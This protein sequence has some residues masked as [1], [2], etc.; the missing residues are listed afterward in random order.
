MSYRLALIAEDISRVAGGVPAVISQ[1][2]R[3]VISAGSSVSLL[4]AKGATSEVE[5]GVEGYQISPNNSLLGKLWQWNSAWRRLDKTPLFANADVVHIH[6]CWSAPQYYASRIAGRNRVPFIFSA[7]GMLE[8]WLWKGLGPLQFLKK[9]IYWNLFAKNALKRARVVHAITTLEEKNLRN[10]FGKNI[11]IVVIP[12]ALD[13]R[14]YCCEKPPV[15]KKEFLFIG[16]IDPKKGVDILLQ[17]FLSANLD[18]SWTLRIVGPV[19]S[20][21]Y[22]HN[23]EKIISSH[24]AGL[25]VSIES[26][27]FGVDK[28]ELV[29]QSWVMVAPSY[30]E[31]VGLVNL[32]AAALETPS[33]TTYQTGLLS[34]EQGGNILVNPDVRELTRAIETAASWRE[35]ERRERG[36]KARDFVVKNYSWDA[37]L[38]MWDQLY[39]EL[40]KP[41]AR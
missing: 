19:W 9:F 41:S 30:S 5:S 34:W 14:S 3:E 15:L 11:R 2:S 13:V 36:K 39:E 29:S 17:A 37:V 6:G 25:R 16:R 35:D 31:V 24:A 8:P 33:I 1:L 27:V 4:Y 12:N 20:K 21:S 38:P 7:H 18:S 22:L 40:A 23:L 32:E 10:L 26:P 28:K